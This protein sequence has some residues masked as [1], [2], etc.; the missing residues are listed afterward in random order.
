MIRNLFDPGKRIPF[1]ER[2][3]LRF[4]DGGGRLA[5]VTNPHAPTVTVAGMRQGGPAMVTDGRFAVPSLTAMMLERG[6]TEFSSMA[7][8]REL[9][10][11]GLH[12]DV[13]S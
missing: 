5:V 7:L 1:S 10:D 4:F 11:H 6:T 13:R 9:E 2:V 8:A 3:V 12:L